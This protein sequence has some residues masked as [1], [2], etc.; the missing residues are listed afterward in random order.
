LPARVAQD[1]GLAVPD[2]G[3]I[4]LSWP[5]GKAGRPHVSYSDL[6]IDFNSQKRKRDPNEFRDKIVV[7]GVTA[8]GLHDIRPTP[9][10]TLYD[11]LGKPL[12]E[13]K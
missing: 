4:L 11:E 1:L 7:I 12:K 6:Y 5:G 10:S 8:S 13:K 2:V 9:V 3:S